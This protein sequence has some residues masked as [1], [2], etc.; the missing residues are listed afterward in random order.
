M[1]VL[2]NGPKGCLDLGIWALDLIVAIL[3]VLLDVL[4]DHLSN[5][6]VSFEWR[7]VVLLFS[8][9]LGLLHHEG[10]CDELRFSGE[11]LGSQHA[12]MVIWEEA[13]M[14]NCCLVGHDFPALEAELVSESLFFAKSKLGGE[15]SP[16]V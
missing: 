1:Q 3:H 14:F 4:L 2:L 8:N 16:F 9:D 12:L 7:F 15:D 5:L 10:N 13:L 6:S 11:L